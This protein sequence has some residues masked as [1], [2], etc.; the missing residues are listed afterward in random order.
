VRFAEGEDRAVSSVTVWDAA[1]GALGASAAHLRDAVISVGSSY[2]SMTGCFL[3]SSS[4]SPP[5]AGFQGRDVLCGPGVT[6]AEAVLSF[7]NVIAGGQG[8]LAVKLCTLP[9]EM[10]GTAT[11]WVKT[12]V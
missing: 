12:S 5:P 2:Q 8:K 1:G 11:L 3:D 6:G 4:A 10:A 9:A 7:P